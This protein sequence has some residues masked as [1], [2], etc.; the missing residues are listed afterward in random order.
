MSTYMT[1]VEAARSSDFAIE[2]MDSLLVKE[3][4]V[5]AGE[6]KSQENR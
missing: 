3:Y 6:P 4:R 2:T 1:A 5:A